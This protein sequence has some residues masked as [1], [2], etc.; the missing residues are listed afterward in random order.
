MNN[1]EFTIQVWKEGP[2]FVSYA[3]EFEVASCGKTTEEARKNIRAA[4]ELFLEETKKMGT[5]E[6]VL[7]EAGFEAGDDSQWRA[8]EMVAYERSRLAV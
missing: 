4:V 7:E 8:P 2:M 5:L 1:I 3:R 6:Q